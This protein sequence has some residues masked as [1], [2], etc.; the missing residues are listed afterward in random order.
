MFHRTMLFSL[1]IGSSVLTAPVAQ[2][3]SWEFW[4]RNNYRNSLIAGGGAAAVGLIYYIWQHVNKSESPEEC[5]ARVQSMLNALHNE[6]DAKIAAFEQGYHITGN[7]LTSK[8]EQLELA[9]QE[10]IARID[11]EALAHLGSFSGNWRAHI[12]GDVKKLSTA[13]IDLSKMRR[14]VLQEKKDLLLAKRM[15]KTL[16]ELSVLFL[17]MSLLKDC[18]K[19][20][21][22]YLDLLDHENTM[23]TR[24]AHVLNI[25]VSQA[26]LKQI[27][28]SNSTEE[29]H[30]Y[31]KFIQALGRD[32]VWFAQK[33]NQANEMVK[34]T[35]LFR[36][37]QQMQNA[38]LAIQ[39]RIHAD[40]TLHH[41]LREYQIELLSQMKKKAKSL[42]N[43]VTKAQTQADQVR[44]LEQRLSL[45]V[46]AYSAY[47]AWGNHQN[48]H[49]H[50]AISNW[51]MDKLRAI[52]Q[53]IEKIFSTIQKARDSARSA[54]KERT[55]MQVRFDEVNLSVPEQLSLQ[56]KIE[57]TIQDMEKI[58]QTM[59][60][61][62]QS[63]RR[64]TDD[65]HSWA[66]N[67]GL[68][69]V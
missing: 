49:Q 41:D 8:N 66:R 64:A 24:Y 21:A 9:R 60:N 23:S 32:T 18:V 63:A 46:A 1:I 29:T 67:N 52:V 27:I 11:E 20:N 13:K 58:G 16:A 12:G 15:E 47:Q 59:H 19:H 33:I 10:W 61:A 25:P 51:E 48:G 40:K 39:K 17:Q 53:D 14:Q 54:E 65:L 68:F 57:E 3:M 5:Y 35:K 56:I 36:S 6:Y 62:E 22:L 69:L 50:N 2:A 44:S 55:R 4:T 45:V 34:R 7:D 42:T 26:N 43:A 37:V 28:C 31:V 38:L 30:P